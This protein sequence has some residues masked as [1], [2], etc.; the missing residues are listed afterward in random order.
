MVAPDPNTEP[1][2]RLTA[3]PVR[4]SQF[5][6]SPQRMLPFDPRLQIYVAEKTGANLVVTAHRP[7]QKSKGREIGKHFFN[8]LLGDAAAALN[9]STGHTSR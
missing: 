6:E 8:S 3:P 4:C 2:T 7:L 9:R 1:Q 5:P